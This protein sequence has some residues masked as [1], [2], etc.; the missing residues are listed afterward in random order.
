[1]IFEN[2]QKWIEHNGNGFIWSNLPT[3]CFHFVLGQVQ[4]RIKGQCP[5]STSNSMNHSFV[6]CE[7]INCSAKVPYMEISIFYFSM[8]R[9]VCLLHCAWRTPSSQ[10]NSLSILILVDSPSKW[11]FYID[12]FE[13]DDTRSERR[14]LHVS[15]RSSLK[16]HAVIIHS[17]F[18]PNAIK[19]YEKKKL[20]RKKN[21]TQNW[22]EFVI[23]N[24]QYAA[25]Q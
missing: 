23:N 1:M 6:F 2:S 8:D 15:H 4:V 11:F 5:V 20:K 17:G 18:G 10:M 13:S 19:N 25:M 16:L 22:T 14:T 12:S 9:H 24:T 3:F 21:T 7:N